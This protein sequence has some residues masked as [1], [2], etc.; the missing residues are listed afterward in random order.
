MT[1]PRPAVSGATNAGLPPP[2]R[3]AMRDQAQATL[4][5]AFFSG[6]RISA[7]SRIV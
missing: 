5:T 7:K 6:C 3:V 2:F 4:E 1:A